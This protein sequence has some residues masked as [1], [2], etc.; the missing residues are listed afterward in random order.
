MWFKA[1]EWWLN[2]QLNYKTKVTKHFT[3]VQLSKRYQ[4]QE[5]QRER[6]TRGE[7]FWFVCLFCFD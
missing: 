6:E 1:N 5:R 3:R 7:E 2:C 4:T